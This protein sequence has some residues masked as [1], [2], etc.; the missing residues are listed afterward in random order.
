ME[1]DIREMFVDLRESPQ[2]LCKSSVC[3]SLYSFKQTI[4][5]DD[6]A[7]VKVVTSTHGREI[8]QV[9][10][11]LLFTSAY[12]FQY[13][14]MFDDLSCPLNEPTVTKIADVER[15]V[16]AFLQHLPAVKGDIT[17]LRSSLISGWYFICVIYFD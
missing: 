2:L 13:I 9:Y 17:I 4:D 10:Q 3:A 6:I 5:R 7:D 12:N 15:E 16:N 11:E 8:F 14:I 1:T